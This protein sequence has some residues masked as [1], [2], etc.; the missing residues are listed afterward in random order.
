[1]RSPNAKPAVCRFWPKCCGPRLESN[2]STNQQVGTAKRLEEQITK[3]TGNTGPSVQ[4]YETLPATGP[5]IK[6]QKRQSELRRGCSLSTVYQTPL[7]YPA[8]DSCVVFFQTPPPLKKIRPMHPSNLQS[9]SLE[10]SVTLILSGTL[11]S[12]K[13]PE[14][15]QDHLKRTTLALGVTISA[16][17]TGKEEAL[18]ARK[19]LRALFLKLQAAHSMDPQTPGRCLQRRAWVP[20]LAG[21]AGLLNPGRVVTA[22]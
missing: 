2:K 1:M 16:P 13:V 12:S 11:P 15:L 3:P 18:L 5:D 22:S 10:I 8:N 21:Q 6:K 14:G 9:R 7:G 19:Q 4:P 17:R 20:T